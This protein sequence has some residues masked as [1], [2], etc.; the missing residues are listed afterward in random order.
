[1]STPTHK[2]TGVNTG[3]ESNLPLWFTLL[4]SLLAR[5]DGV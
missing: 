1:M 3:D 5:H 2:T 4:G